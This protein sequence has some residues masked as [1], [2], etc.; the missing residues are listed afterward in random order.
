MRRN[1]IVHRFPDLGSS[2]GH[3]LCERS[4]DA[5]KGKIAPKDG[6]SS[7]LAFDHKACRRPVTI[8]GASLTM[9]L[10]IAQ[11]LTDNAS[12]PTLPFLGQF[13]IDFGDTDPF[14]HG[15]AKT[16]SGLFS[17]LWVEMNA[18]RLRASRR[19][20]ALKRE[21]PY[22][23]MGNRALI[24]RLSVY[25]LQRHLVMSSD[26]SS[27]QHLLDWFMHAATHKNGR[28]RGPDFRKN[29]ICARIEAV[30]I[31]KIQ[32]GLKRSPLKLTDCLQAAQSLLSMRQK[33][34]I[35]QIKGRRLFGYRPAQDTGPRCF[36]S[37]NQ[38]I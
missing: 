30:R 20:S 38:T 31:I 11:Q 12:D 19:P 26:P 18:R 6:F 22:V 17:S 3:A 7:L 5:Q 32:I 29:Q 1:I 36:A 15:N 9:A 27:I 10:R 34:E 13:P 4:S 28:Y 37:R 2:A 25:R 14:I 33:G 16:I 21:G 8:F 24:D 35:L 23:A